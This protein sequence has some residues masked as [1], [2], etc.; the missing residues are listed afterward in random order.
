[1]NEQRIT[2][3]D[4]ALIYLNEQK[5]TLAAASAQNGAMWHQYALAVNTALTLRKAAL[6]SGIGVGL[7][8]QQVVVAAQAWQVCM[9][10]QSEGGA[11]AW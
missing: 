4:A 3:I 5:S 2:N 1:M 6:L 10:V 8:N 11:G 9:D 7:R